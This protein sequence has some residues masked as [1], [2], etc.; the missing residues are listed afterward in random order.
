MIECGITKQHPLEWFTH[1]IGRAIYNEECA[2]LQRLLALIVPGRIMQIG[3]PP[4]IRSFSNFHFIHYDTEVFFPSIGHNVC[5]DFCK[6]P[7]ADSSFNIIT[8]PHFHEINNDFSGLLLECYRVLE[9]EGMLLLYGFNPVSIWGVQRLLGLG[10]VVPWCK[11]F[12]SIN[13]VL[14]E[15]D[16]TDFTLFAK[17]SLYLGLYSK[18][19]AV[20]ENCRLM[21]TS[22]KVK[23]GAVYALLF[24]KRTATMTLN[25]EINKYYK[26]N[27]IV[28][29]E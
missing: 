10:D 27:A 24:C 11:R 18:H 7:F 22:G 12:Y 23:F 17:D 21:N 16:K 28:I 20:F 26:P 5:G 14:L 8:M 25:T 4:L 13:S 19:R 29:P 6:L 2:N 3:G 9:D 15:I 1:D